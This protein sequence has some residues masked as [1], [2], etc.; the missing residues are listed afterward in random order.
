MK[1]LIIPISAILLLLVTA[2]AFAW[3][4]YK[5]HQRARV[6]RQAQAFLAAGDFPNASLCAR[7]LLQLQPGNLDAC[8]IMAEMG[9]AGHSP[10]AVYWRQR[11]AAEA[12]TFSNRLALAAAALRL[13]RPPYVLA[14]QTLREL[15]PLGRTVP[16]FHVLSAELALKASRL[17][18]AKAHFEQAAALEPAN[19]LHRFNL[20]VLNLRSTNQDMTARGRLT[21]EQFS[22][23]RDLAVLALRWR[24]AEDLRRSDVTGA[25]R[26]SEELLARPG[27]DFPDQLQHLTLLRLA[28]SPSFSA[29]LQKVQL[30]AV[31]NVAYLCSTS[32]WMAKYGLADAALSWLYGLDPKLRKTPALPPALAKLHL[33]K[34]DWPGLETLL[35]GQNWADTEF[36]RLAFLARAAFGRQLETVGESRWR[37]AIDAAGGRLGSLTCLLGLA[38]DWNCDPEGLLWEIGRR[39]PRETWALAELERRFQFTG[40]TRG[41]NRIYSLRLAGA[42]G[43]ADATNRNDFATTSLL[44]KINLAQAHQI[45]RELFRLHPDDP[46]LGSTYAYSLHLQGRTREGLN[47]FSRFTH[48]ELEVPSIALYYGVLLARSNTP[49]RAAP[50]LARAQAASLLPEERDLLEQARAQR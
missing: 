45:A 16:A 42:D 38:M 21:L 22:T 35:S 28:Q 30:I 3:P 18:E 39:F 44:L 37:A 43:A 34:Q 47:V 7:E 12:P 9:E 13:Q 24:I 36:L 11:I 14:A 48:Q 32:E 20:A 50:Y 41:L 23:N 46:V 26:L 1:R 29:C 17:E 15:E 6:L 49:E 27:A 2:A 19:A 33:V 5:R 40:N 10:A 4:A 25:L 31:T 8:R